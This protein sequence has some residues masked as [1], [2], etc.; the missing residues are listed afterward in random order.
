MFEPVQETTPLTRNS[1]EASAI[2]SQYT[3]FLDSIHYEVQASAADALRHAIINSSKS[4]AFDSRVLIRLLRLLTSLD[5]D[6]QC[7]AAGAVAAIAVR[8][9]SMLE[10]LRLRAIPELVRL[11]AC[12]SIEVQKSAVMA[13][14]KITDHE[15]AVTDAVDADAIK[16]LVPILCTTD[17][18]TLT[19]TCELLKKLT[20]TLER[21]RDAALD[22][23]AHVAL[24]RCLGSSD[25]HVRKCAAEALQNITIH[26]PAHMETVYAGGI[27]AF[28]EALKSST[29][30]VLQTALCE[31]LKNLTMSCEPA[32][33]AACGENVVV[34][35]VEFFARVQVQ[36]SAARAVRN[37]TVRQTRATSVA[38]SVIPALVR[39]LANFDDDVKIASCSA[40]KNVDW[41]V[42]RAQDAG[43]SNK[44][45]TALVCLLDSGN[46][47]VVKSVAMTLQ[48]ITTHC[49]A[50]VTGFE[51]KVISLLF[52]LLDSGDVDVQIAGCDLLERL[53]RVQEYAGVAASDTKI[54][55]RVVALLSS[56]SDSVQAIAMQNFD[57]MSSHISMQEA[58][59]KWDAIPRVVQ[60]LASTDVQVQTS[61]ARSL[62]NITVGL[63]A[64]ATAVDAGAISALVRLLQSSDIDLKTVTCQTL[65]HMVSGS[66]QARNAACDAHV[67]P[68]L[69]HLLTCEQAQTHALGVLE[70]TTLPESGRVAA[71]GSNSIPHLVSILASRDP[72]VQT[73]VA[74][75]LRN[76][77]VF[78]PAVQAAVDANAIPP[79]VRLL[80]SS[81]VNV[82]SA[83]CEA[84]RNICWTKE[85]AQAAAFRA[86]AVQSLIGLLSHNDVRVQQSAVHALEK[87]VLYD[88]AKEAACE[89]IPVLVRLLASDNLELQNRAVEALNMITT[90]KTSAQLAALQSEAIP[91]L[92]RLINSN[93]AKV[94]QPAAQALKSITLLDAAEAVAVEAN[95]IPSLVKRLCASDVSVRL[96]ACGALK[97]IVWTLQPAR[98]AAL[99]ANAIPY[100]VNLLRSDSTDV[101]GEATVALEK[102]CSYGPGSLA[103]FRGNA[104]P[105]LV[106][107]LDS[108]VLQ[109]YSSAANTFQYITANEQ[110][111]Q[112]AFDADAVPALVK[113]LKRTSNVGIQ[114][115]VCRALSNI[116]GTIVRARGA[117]WSAGAITILLKLGFHDNDELQALAGQIA[118][119]LGDYGSTKADK[120][121]DRIEDFFGMF[122]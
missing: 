44:V 119:L 38:P 14:R 88:P 5:V 9:P 27:P 110:A 51:S 64:Q 31:T 48:S 111:R 25:A 69:L 108:G 10:E 22:T 6:V 72:M 30:P 94:H 99:D 68:A 55:R 101:Q 93:N 109:V 43:G 53:A 65:M 66:E 86:D 92:V 85:Q 70:Q 20:S 4:A 80:S 103:A 89:S 37:I 58:A 112:S 19:A 42:K 114:T 95:A 56:K 15:E 87:V 102:I 12:S 57:H 84:L 76:V 8:V 63:P 104:I 116:T 24:I 33:D 79:L 23:H 39:H 90:R 52:Q 34:V 81:D 46:I 17:T 67:V 61:A 26:P 83:A 100:L 16:A 122:D 91:A 59:L 77:T 115:D 18:S 106:P 47:E 28:I 82:L 60:L 50:M 36:K 13:L 75:S 35:L 74:R 98:A 41:G 120:I 105:A 32:R 71:F 45:M 7:S 1:P 49:R 21:A 2:K 96:A 121:V 29:D 97:H 117:A 40:L 113:L 54:A 118:E 78:V 107:L 3:P 62:R 11:L 73:L